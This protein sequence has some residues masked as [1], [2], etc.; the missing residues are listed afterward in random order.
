MPVSRKEFLDIQATMK[1]R[2]T[3]KRVHDMIRTYI[4][5]NQGYKKSLLSLVTRIYLENRQVWKIFLGSYNLDTRL[6]FICQSK[7]MTCNN[8]SQNYWN[9]CFTFANYNSC[10]LICTLKTEIFVAKNLLQ[11]LSDKFFVCGNFAFNRHDF[12]CTGHLDFITTNDFT[13]L[14]LLS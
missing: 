4:H 14:R 2:F 1:C 5:S 12:S 9:Y 11:K 10:F 6:L 3:L 13:C 8:Q 7:N